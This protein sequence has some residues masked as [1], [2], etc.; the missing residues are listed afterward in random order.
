VSTEDVKRLLHITG[1]VLG[2][3]ALGA[4]YPRM[5]GV[6]SLPSAAASMSHHSS[7]V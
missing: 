5:P 3:G 2:A 7:T 1:A 4:L 6:F